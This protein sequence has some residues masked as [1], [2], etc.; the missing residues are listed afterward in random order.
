MT[1]KT[2]QCTTVFEGR[3]LKVDKLDV[4]LVDGKR[5]VREIVRH[6]GA[7]VVLVQLPD[8]RFVLVRQYRKA[9][10][11]DLLEAV[12]GTLDPGED[13]LFCAK[14]EVEE[15][16]GYTVDEIFPLGHMYPAPGYTQE[17]LHMFFARVHPEQG[18]QRPD[19][20]EKVDVCHLSEREL[21]DCIDGGEIVDAKTIA[22]W[23][24][25]TRRRSM[26]E[27]GEV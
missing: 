20:D 2:I 7:A 19:D 27:G 9:V 21:V 26:I 3:L 10:E 1:E 25:F 22:I 6:P 15:E 17:K 12:A 23:H 13:A 16:T 18:A 14:R 8:K 24:I 11:Q 5:S 4:E